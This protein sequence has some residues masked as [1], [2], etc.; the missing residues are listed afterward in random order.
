V[1]NPALGTYSVFAW[2]KG[3]APGQV[4]ISQSDG[5]GTGEIWLGADTSDGKLMTGL[6]PPG[7]RSPTPPMV[8]DF[9]ITDGQWHHVGIVVT[10]NRVRNLYADGVRVAFDTQGVSLPSSNGGMYF[11]T[12]KNL[13]ATS[14]FSGLIDDIRIYNRALTAEEIAALVQ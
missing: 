14:L 11:G 3:G 6:R 10:S 13:D 4:I 8:S 12:D 2:I 7:G 1:L 5:N 9:V